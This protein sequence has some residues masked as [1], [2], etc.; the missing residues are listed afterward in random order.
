[1][2][3]FARKVDTLTQKVQSIDFV[4]VLIIFC[5]GSTALLVWWQVPLYYDEISFRKSYAVM[6]RDQAIYRGPFDLC[7][8]QRKDIP[9]VFY[10]PAYILSFW[11]RYLT[12]YTF[13][14]LSFFC[15]LFLILSSTFIV[16][17]QNN[18]HFAFFI[19]VG[20]IGIS[21]SSLIFARYEILQELNLAVCLIG[22]LYALCGKDDKKNIIII[23]FL[24]LVSSL[25]SVYPHIQGLLFLPITAFIGLV[26]LLRARINP[27]LS[28]AWIVFFIYIIFSA[29]KFHSFI[30]NEYPEIQSYSEN[31]I[32]HFSNVEPFSLLE[33]ARG[34]IQKYTEA[35]IYKETFYTEFYIPALL[36]LNKHQKWLISLLN[37]AIRITIISNLLL[38]SLCFLCSS[39]GFLKYL[40]QITIRAKNSVHCSMNMYLDNDTVIFQCACITISTCVIFLFT[41]D[42]SQNFYRSIFI[43]F[44][45]CIAIALYMSSLRN[46]YTLRAFEIYACASIFVF[47]LT[48]TAN[49]V[50]FSSK[51]S[52]KNG[53]TGPLVSIN[54][55][56]NEL[57][58]K[59]SEL[60]NKCEAN[61]DDGEIVMDDY[62]YNSLKLYPHLSAITF[63]NLH[64]F[65]TKKSIK[66]LISERK[67]NYAIARCTSL[68]DIYEFAQNN[69]S[70]KNGDI[71]CINFK[72]LK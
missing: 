11:D 10:L 66:N 24:L 48:V 61:L 53:Y 69:K 6:F 35:F 71:C 46:Y 56:W 59:I 39:I 7:L 20:L 72:K 43:N 68:I 14:F 26:I 13:R 37:T 64:S 33:L 32:I 38:L 51:L 29:V 30:C 55:D 63:L 21:G 49:Y 50:Y 1:M 45:C 27:M 57:D 8:S 19:L 42:V 65:V 2:V 22:L 3:R 12:P 36:G 60:T 54:M 17:R 34:K 18:K 23:L 40:M 4:F 28:M 41:Y 67:P 25:L 31:M 44:I 47:L 9:I 5:L 52:G 16:V 58:N 70:E 15:V 62:S